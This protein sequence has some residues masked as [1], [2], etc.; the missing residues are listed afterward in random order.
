MVKNKIFNATSFLLAWICFLTFTAN[1]EQK[2]P[3]LAELNQNHHGAIQQYIYA[4][5]TRL[6]HYII[7]KYSDGHHL[8]G[9]DPPSDELRELYK[10]SNFD[11]IWSR[12]HSIID[13]G[14]SIAYLPSRDEISVALPI[15]FY[16]ST[17]R[18]FNVAIAQTISIARFALGLSDDYGTALEPL[19]KSNLEAAYLLYR[20][21]FPFSDWA[22]CQDSSLDCAEK[23][24]PEEKHIAT[25]LMAKINVGITIRLPVENS[26]M[27]YWSDNE[28]F[29]N[30]EFWCPKFGY[31]EGGWSLLTFLEHSIGHGHTVFSREEKNRGSAPVYRI[32]DLSEYAKKRLNAYLKGAALCAEKGHDL[33]R[34]TIEKSIRDN[35]ADNIWLEIRNL[36]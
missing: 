22:A 36:H 8:D 25:A 31:S 32:P 30:L 12:H 16:G 1:A 10:L 23:G 18:E 3:T 15:I 4:S 6:R 13:S 2:T 26:Q 5:K 35:T 28:M 11:L 17:N 34:L 14:A 20:K 33:R 7:K 21:V 9:L 19:V 27:R 24:S 29:N